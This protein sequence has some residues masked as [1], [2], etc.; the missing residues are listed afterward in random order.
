MRSGHIAG[1]GLDVWEQEPPPLDHPLMAFE[2]VVVNFHTAGVTNEARRNTAS[3]SG[4][5]VVGI[6][7]GG[8]PPRI[9]NPEAWPAYARRF[10]QAFGFP[11]QTSAKD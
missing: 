10:E 8:Y 1:A 7:K 4:E 9:I 3:Y 6:L 2:N 11:V 5:Q